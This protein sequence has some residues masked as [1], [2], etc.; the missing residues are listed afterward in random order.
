VDELSASASEVL[1]GALQDWCRAKIVGRRTFGKGLVQEQ[2]PLG[3]G[4]ALRLTVARYYTPIGAVFN[5]PTKREKNIY[6]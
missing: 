6:G 1:A 2:F 3:D 5:A 4:S